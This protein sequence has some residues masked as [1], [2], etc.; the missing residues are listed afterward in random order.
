MK[1]LIS[2][3]L[4]RSGYIKED[5]NILIYHLANEEKEECSRMVNTNA[6]K[7]DKYFALLVSVGNKVRYINIGRN[8]NVNLTDK[9][10]CFFEP[11]IFKLDKYF[12]KIGNMIIDLYKRSELYKRFPKLE[13]EIFSNAYVNQ[14]TKA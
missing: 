10:T 9:P 12:D 13:F 1:E 4:T 2:K 6:L 3:V 8:M 7:F 11:D 5:K 14:A